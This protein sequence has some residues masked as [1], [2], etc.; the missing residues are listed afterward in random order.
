MAGTRSASG[1]M[2]SHGSHLDALIPRPKNP[3]TA[4]PPDVRKKLGLSKRVDEE[5]DEIWKPGSGVLAPVGSG[6]DGQYLKMKSGVS[7]SIGGSRKAQLENSGVS[8]RANI[9]RPKLLLT[10]AKSY[11]RD[12]A[13]KYIS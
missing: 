5:S 6:R 4:L 7:L 8:R 10:D 9:S 12:E 3:K 1:L 13:F 2:C 11:N